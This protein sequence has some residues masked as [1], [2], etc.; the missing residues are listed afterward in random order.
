MKNFKGIL[1]PLAV[2][3]WIGLVC[4]VITLAHRPAGGGGENHAA[5]SVARLA[6]A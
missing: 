6:R 3:A 2:I 5:R 1:E 4:L